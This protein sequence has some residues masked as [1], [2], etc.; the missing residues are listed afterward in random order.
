MDG[1]TQQ[2]PMRRNPPT[3]VSPDQLDVKSVIFK[4][5][6]PPAKVMIAIRTRPQSQQL[7]EF[8]AL[9]SF[10]AAQLGNHFVHFGSTPKPI[11]LLRCFVGSDFSKQFLNLL[12]VRFYKLD[13]S[14]IST[15]PR[16]MS[17]ASC[18]ILLC[19]VIWPFV[20]FI[21]ECPATSVAQKAFVAS[22]SN[23]YAIRLTPRAV[24]SP[25]PLNRYPARRQARQRW[26]PPAS[27][28]GIH[29]SAV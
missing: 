5:L 26:W 18:P 22:L 11:N 27:Q 21:N 23:L 19:G 2:L 4:T 29:R 10:W 24:E 15:R 16:S 13:R 20:R 25:K 17:R 12:T 6:E 3:P 28:R 14:F 8:E 9:R 7:H 1:T